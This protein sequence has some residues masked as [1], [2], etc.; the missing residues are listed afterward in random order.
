MLCS[1]GDG[2]AVCFLPPSCW[3]IKTSAYATC[4]LGAGGFL[5]P[6]AAREQAPSLW[7]CPRCCPRGPTCQA[8]A[9][10]TVV[11]SGAVPRAGGA[12]VTGQA[13]AEGSEPGHAA[14][15][16]GE[17]GV[18]CCWGASGGAQTVLV[19]GT[20]PRCAACKAWVHPASARA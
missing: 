3:R 1:L 6:G 10:L 19:M 17:G 16:T 8:S 13:S 2:E 15:C 18:P 5:L 9:R 12:C 11:P 7:L 14:G 4:V 20:E